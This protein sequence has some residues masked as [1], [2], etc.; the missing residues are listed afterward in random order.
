MARL[1][2][3][4]RR[5]RTIGSMPSETW[6]EPMMLQ[7]IV[8]RLE[9]VRRDHRA[10]STRRLRPGAPGV[11]DHGRRGRG[12]PT[13]G[14]S[15]RAHSRRRGGHGTAV[16][17][18]RS[19]PGQPIGK[20][21]YMSIV[22]G[23]KRPKIGWTVRVPTHRRQP[24]G[25]APPADPCLRDAQRQTE[26]FKTHARNL[27]SDALVASAR[28][29]GGPSEPHDHARRLV[30]RSASASSTGNGWSRPA[31]RLAR[32]RPKRPA[33]LLIVGGRAS[34]D[35]PTIS[36]MDRTSGPGRSPVPTRRRPRRADRLGRATTD[37]GARRA[38]AR[39]RSS[40]PAAD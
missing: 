34:W 15:R 11:D 2:H 26:P 10:N 16:R 17:H 31:C 29:R 27:R 37:G 23:H 33:D 20:S 14:G 7:Q 5:P 13:W 24:R 28:L 1:S 38:A 4:R 8:V 6:V 21:R 12:R 18:D 30:L 40:T 9:P 32:P 22:P 3:S 25:E 36:P 19:S 39:P 35:G